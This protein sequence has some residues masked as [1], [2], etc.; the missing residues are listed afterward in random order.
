MSEKKQNESRKPLAKAELFDNG[1]DTYQ[2]VASVDFGSFKL[3]IDKTI[4]MRED[5]QKLK[6]QRH[7]K[8]VK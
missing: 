7:L 2:L 5:E 8:T 6:K 3:E 4:D 1:D